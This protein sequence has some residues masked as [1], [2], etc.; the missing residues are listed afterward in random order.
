[1]ATVE[2]VARENG[3]VIAALRPDGTAVF[4]ADDALHAAVARARRQRGR[5]LTFALRR[6][7]RRA[8]ATPR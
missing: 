4:P 8:P 2:A 3:A 7:G 5:M 6:R 1:M